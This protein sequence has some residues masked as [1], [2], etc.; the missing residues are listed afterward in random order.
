MAFER[1]RLG[2]RWLPAGSIQARVFAGALVLLPAPLLFPPAFLMHV[3]APM[4][5]V[6]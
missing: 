3:I 5:G 4:T 2:V 1:T 6:T